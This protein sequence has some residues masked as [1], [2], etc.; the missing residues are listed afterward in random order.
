MQTTLLS[1]MH[2]PA[3]YVA[4]RGSPRA[5]NRDRRLSAV[6]RRIFRSGEQGGDRRLRAAWLPRYSFVT[7]GVSVQN[8]S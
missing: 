7:Y 4:Y 5:R 8:A 1:E 3:R 6:Q 2:N